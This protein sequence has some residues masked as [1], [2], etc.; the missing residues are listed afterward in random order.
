MEG[1]LGLVITL[2]L[3]AFKQ[4]ICSFIG[5]STCGIMRDYSIT[6]KCAYKGRDESHL[7]FLFNAAVWM[8]GGHCGY[9]HCNGENEE[10]LGVVMPL[11]DRPT[12]LLI[13]YVPNPFRWDLI[14]IIIIIGTWRGSIKSK[15]FSRTI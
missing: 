3:L 14:I 2:C 8:D 13:L 6:F 1:S 7:T 12:A 15:S 11:G 4:V 10:I 9:R 5:E